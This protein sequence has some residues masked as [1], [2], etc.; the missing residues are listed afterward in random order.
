MTPRISF[1]VH[2]TG[3]INAAGINTIAAVPCSYKLTIL[4]V[5]FLDKYR[6][7]RVIIAYVKLLI[8]PHTIP[9]VVLFSKENSGIVIATP[10]IR[11]IA[12]MILFARSL[13]L[14]TIGS[15]N[16]RNKGNVENVIVPI[17]TEET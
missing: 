3:T 11:I 2:M 5:Y 12:L 14:N 4:P 6:L 13:S 16:V 9:T 1:L 7:E 10:A 15:I 8:I 17:A